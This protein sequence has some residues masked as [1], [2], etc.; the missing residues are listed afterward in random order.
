MI[1]EGMSQNEWEKM[2]TETLTQFCRRKKVVW[3]EMLHQIGHSWGP[4]IVEKLYD[5]GM[6]AG[7]EYRNVMAKISIREILAM[8][9]AVGSTVMAKGPVEVVRFLFNEDHP[10]S[11]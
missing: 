9:V 8:Q 1:N 10:R 7:H 11:C 5:I 3:L 2:T 4:A 6:E